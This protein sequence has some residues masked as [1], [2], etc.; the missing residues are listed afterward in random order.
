MTAVLYSFCQGLQL[1]MYTITVSSILDNTISSEHTKV[2]VERDIRLYFEGMRAN[3]LNL[4]LISPLYYVFVYLFLLNNLKEGFYLLDY[5]S[6]L[7]IHNV[8]YYAIHKMMH[9]I[10]QLKGFHNFHH[11][12]I[13]VI[14]SNGNAV[15]LM[16]FN[17]AYISPFIGGIYL[18]SPNNDTLKSAI[19]TISFL[20]TFIHCPNFA[21]LELPDIIVSPAKHI[22]HHK[23]CTMETYAAPLLNIDY[24]VNEIQKICDS[25][26]QDYNFVDIVEKLELKSQTE[27]GSD[28][29]IQE[30]IGRIIDNFLLRRQSAIFED[31]EEQIEEKEDDNE[32]IKD[33]ENVE[34]EVEVE[35]DEKEDEDEM[36]DVDVDKEEEVIENKEK[37]AK[38]ED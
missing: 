11:L 10:P 12:F 23:K 1:G 35:V 4:L 36:V 7:L 27:E 34:V 17:L 2:L 5:I 3:Y 14:P 37:I 19:M 8:G 31:D 18:I 32:Q 26:V 20:N 25:F 16:E 24:I 28:V 9:K 22:N 6:L 15:S 30:E 29:N 38:K 21:D 33:N 13:D